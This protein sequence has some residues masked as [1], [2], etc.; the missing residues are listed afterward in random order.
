[1]VFLCVW[2]FWK[3]VLTIEKNDSYFSI[4]YKKILK[5]ELDTSFAIRAFGKACV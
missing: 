5:E 1:M 4:L 3:P 2:L